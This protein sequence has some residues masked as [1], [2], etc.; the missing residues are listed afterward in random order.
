M[1]SQREFIA[2]LN[3]LNFTELKDNKLFTANGEWELSHTLKLVPA[4]VGGVQ[5]V[6]YV[7]YKGQVVSVWG[8]EG[9]E[10]V[11]MAEYILKLRASAERKKLRENR[12]AMDTGEILF[13]AL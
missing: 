6:V 7:K 2:K 12:E 1:L 8:C 5:I 4:H 10:Q 9:E 13:N 11:E 3:K